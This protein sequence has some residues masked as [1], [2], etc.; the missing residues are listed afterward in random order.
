MSG[1]LR[2]RARARVQLFWLVLMLALVVGGAA[3]W[4]KTPVPA[5]LT[6]SVTAGSWTYSQEY[7]LA[8]GPSSFGSMQYNVLLPQGY[9]PTLYTYPLMIVGGGNDT[10]MNGATYPAAGSTFISSMEGNSLRFNTVAFRT[11]HPAVIIAV[12]CDQTLDLSGSSTDSN[13]GG[14]NDSANGTWNEQAISKITQYAIANYSINTNQ[15]YCV[16]LS[17]TGI[18][19]LAQLV[20]NNKQYSTGLQLFTAAVGFSDQLYRPATA[21]SSVYSRMQPVPFFSV[22]TPGDNPCNYDLP[23]WQSVTGNTS[24]PTKA[25]YDSGGVAATQAGTT[26]FNL[27]NLPSG[28]AYGTFGCMNADGC[29]GT[30]IYAWLFAQGA[31]SPPPTCTASV[32]NFTVP[33]SGS[34]ITDS[35]CNVWTISGGGATQVNGNAV[36]GSSGVSKLAYVNGVVWQLSGSNWAYLSPSTATSATTA[37]LGPAFGLSPLQTN[38]WT[39]PGQDGWYWKLPFQTTASWL[40]SGSLVTAMQNGTHSSPYAFA[41]LYPN[42][43]A[44]FYQGQATDPVV[45]VT[46][47]STSFQTHLPLGAVP[48]SPYGTGTDSSIGGT[49]VSQPGLTWSMSGVSLTVNGSAVSSVQATGTVITGTYGLEVDWGFGPYLVDA[50]TGQQGACNSCG[51][52]QDYELTQANANATYVIP[53]M[54]TLQMDDSQVNRAIVWPLNVADGTTSTTGPLSQGLTLGIPAS[55]PRPG[56][57]TRGQ[58]LLFDT[59]QQM[60]GLVYNFGPVGGTSFQIYSTAGGNSALVTD[61]VN[62]AIQGGGPGGTSWIMQY[63]A[64]LNNQTGVSSQKGE[65][66]GVRSDAFAAP[67]PLSLQPTGGK[68]VSSAT[69]GAYFP[70]TTAPYA[71]SGGYTAPAPLITAP[72]SISAPLSYPTPALVGLAVNEIWYPSDTLNFTAHSS[73]SGKLTATGATGNGSAT[74][75]FSG[76]QSQT[77]AMLATLSF[78]DSVPENPTIYFTVSDQHSQIDTATTAVAS[79]NTCPA[80][81]N[82]TVL[83]A[84]TGNVITDSVSNAWGLPVSG[85]KVFLNGTALPTTAAAVQLAYVSNVVWYESSANIWYSFNS[86]GG[87]TSSTTTSPLQM[88]ISAPASLAAVQSVATNVSPVS[89]NDAAY[90]ADTQNFS[91]SSTLHGILGM[92]GATGSGTGTIT[93]SGSLSALN[94]ALATLAFQDPTVENATISYSVTDQHSLSASTTTAVSVTSG[95]GTSGTTWNP[96]AIGTSGTL[97]NAN[98]TMTTTGSTNVLSTTSK[99]AGKLCFTVTANALTYN[100]AAGLATSAQGLTGVYLGGGGAPSEALYASYGGAQAVYNAG[101]LVASI[102]GATSA[103]GDVI[104]EAVDL[105]VGLFWV[106]DTAMRTAGYSWNDS[107]SANP[108]T[109][110]GGFLTS[111]IGSGPYFIAAGSQES[112]SSFTINPTPVGCPAGFT[113]WDVTNPTGHSPLI[114]TIQ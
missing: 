18:G 4:A 94:T 24:Y 100:W 13:C 104:M 38:W 50:Q 9:N 92:S 93:F 110:T 95:S 20:D 96:A 12:Q 52:I 3:A 22:C 54:L 67:P 35:G 14:Y 109:G 44:P 57:M 75:T 40:T 53:H 26:A 85:G 111:S 105:N 76:N 81:P 25:T 30:A 108:A 86:S 5:P 46:L 65:V 37:A 61:M 51:I 79:G 45:T 72:A 31:S 10:G 41:I 74:L 112:G 103:P 87:I 42:Y 55:T 68:E 114:I 66:G 49:D 2:V 15:V 6:G 63:L 59:M 47:G 43:A 7:A 1:R 106:T 77:N 69:V 8:G 28:T 102:T 34:S 98:L 11:A 82:N 23:F 70:T 91:A 36:A 29:D 48:E 97:S 17:L 56:G 113:T 32:N 101:T 64:I 107:T 71:K 84:N 80:S 58:A 27:I 83:T 60:G 62:N 88:T 39:N 99:G 33:A 73:G 90:P 78:S 16:G 19:C 21:N 89:A